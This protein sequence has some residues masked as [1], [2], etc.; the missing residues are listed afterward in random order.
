MKSITKQLIVVFTFLVLI[1]GAHAAPSV[2]AP[3]APAEQDA[4][5]NGIIAVVHNYSAGLLRI[6][7]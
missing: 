5:D 1:A 2:P 6:P 4:L 3:L 7:S